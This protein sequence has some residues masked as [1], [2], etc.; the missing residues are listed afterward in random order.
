MNTAIG[1][2]AGKIAPVTIGILA[3]IGVCVLV[4]WMM[5]MWVNELA[6][7]IIAE[8]KAK[9]AEHAETP[10]CPEC[11]LPM[12]S[13]TQEEGPEAGGKTWRCRNYPECPVTRKS[14]NG[15]EDENR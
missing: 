7:R 4:A 1:S 12:I 10:A 6:N 2:L 11:G 5:K 13:E 8:R 15:G 3:F 9:A 14:T